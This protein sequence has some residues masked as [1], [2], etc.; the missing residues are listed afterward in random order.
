MRVSDLLFPGER[1]FRHALESPRA[2]LWIALL[3]IGVGGLYGIWVA[4]FQLALGTD[5]QGIPVARIPTWLL[6][7]GNALAGMMIATIG[8][9]GIALITWLMVRAVGAPCP[10]LVLYRTTAYLLPAAVLAAPWL[11]LT[12]GAVVVGDAGD[13][14]AG[15]MPRLWIYAL[16]AATGGG[17]FLAGLFS[18]LRLVPGLSPFRAAFATALVVAFSAAI[19]LIA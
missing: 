5:L 9:L 8:H 16:L 19:L 18:L 4:A 11:A 3:L 1:T 13:G 7:A 15:A 12:G 2:G 17:F 6:F 14:A 10:L